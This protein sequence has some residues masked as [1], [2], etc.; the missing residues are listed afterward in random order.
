MINGKVISVMKRELQD[1]LMSKAFI[2]STILLPVFMF[3]IIGIQTLL[4]SYKGDA[5]T[6]VEIISQNDYL[7]AK[8]E[9]SISELQVVKDGDY[10]ISFS[11]LM[12]SD[13]KEYVKEKRE[14]LTSERLHAIIYIPNSA[15]ENK[16]IEYYTKAPTNRSIPDRLNGS[17]NK[18]LIE[19]YFSKKDLTPDE[20]E[21][22][23]KSIDLDG[24]KV[25]DK[26][27]FEEESYGNVILSYLLMFLLYISLLMNGQMTMQSVQEEKNSKVVEV[28][29]SSVSSKELMTGKILGASITTTLQMAIWLLP[30]IALISTTWFTIPKEFMID[31]TYGHIIYLLVN[32]FLGLLIFIGLFATIGA[33]FQNSQEAQSGMWPVMLLIMIP[34]FI[35]L[36][37]MRNPGNPI[38]EIASLLPFSTIMVMPGRYTLIDLPVWQL[39]LSL[40]INVLTIAAIFPIAGK[41]Y[42]VG[43]LRTGKKP[44]WG[45][46]I[47]WIKYK[48]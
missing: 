35:A 48:Y 42:R 17:I 8:F 24:F 43:I 26:E 36:S 29:L 23:R 9:N 7:T 34:F 47:K 38:A 30:V 28:L 46:I 3:G 44:T 37:M 45:E 13:I 5:D 2:I 12:A 41:I 11:T 21:F 27:D 16:K 31:I 4:I 15:L 25:S 40:L 22:A 6:V 19:E 18:V 32:F 14:L 10:K 39:L 20:L 1:K 33:V